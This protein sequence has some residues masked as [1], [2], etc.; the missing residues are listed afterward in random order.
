MIC[1]LK[2]IT[3]KIDIAEPKYRYFNI[4][5][6]VCLTI[7]LSV[8]FY[9]YYTIFGSACACC[10]YQRRMHDKT[11]IS[12]NNNNNNSRPVN[13]LKLHIQQQLQPHVRVL[14][15][16]SSLLSTAAAAAAA[17]AERPSRGCGS[18]TFAPGAQLWAARP[19]NNNGK[20]NAIAT[21]SQCCCFWSEHFVSSSPG[22]QRGRERE[23]HCESECV[24]NTLERRVRK[25]E[26]GS[27][28]VPVCVC[29]IEQQLTAASRR[30]AASVL[31]R[32]RCLQ[33]RNFACLL[34]SVLVPCFG[35]GLYLLCFR[36]PFRLLVVDVVVVVALSVCFVVCGKNA[37]KLFVVH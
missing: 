29:K 8:L 6:Y 10:E 22:R 4:I 2:S 14:S 23:R 3:I 31:L 5:I 21:R 26:R 13:P 16:A 37:T 1:G 35:F 36:F 33:H 34:F 20:Q 24:E 27:A 32:A 9:F 11:G 18:V 30:L 19:A 28:C 7:L 17:A 15:D 12:N 25:G